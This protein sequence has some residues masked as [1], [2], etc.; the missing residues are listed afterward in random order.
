LGHITPPK[1]SNN[2]SFTH[3]LSPA[4]VPIC[5]RSHRWVTH[6]QTRGNTLWF[7]GV[8]YSDSSPLTQEAG[9]SRYIHLMRRCAAIFAGE[10]SRDSRIYSLPGSSPGSGH[11]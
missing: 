4:W 6:R 7:W 1:I 5:V 10:M 3:F 8:F 11:R 2:S 9:W